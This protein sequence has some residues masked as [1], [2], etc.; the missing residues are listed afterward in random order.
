MTRS[1]RGG[2]NRAAPPHI[3]EIAGP[4]AIM[5]KFILEIVECPE[6]AA[7]AEVADRF[8]LDS[9][10]GP[11]EHAI[12]RCVV[13][14]R[15]TVL[16]ERLASSPATCPGAGGGSPAQDRGRRADAGRPRHHQR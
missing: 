12:V 3:P 13:R 7:P 6:C 2:R 14:H 10:D 15:F 8:L 5:P 9:T 4:E 1:D 11:I 16:A